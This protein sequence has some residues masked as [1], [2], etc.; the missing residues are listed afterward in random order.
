MSMNKRIFIT[1]VLMA[2][3]FIAGKLVSSRDS[4][5]ASKE[6][7]LVI[8]NATRTAG[9]SA[10]KAAPTSM[11][12]GETAN[13]RADDPNRRASENPAGSVSPP[14]S[15]ASSQSTAYLSPEAAREVL[16]RVSRR[17][18]YQWIAED[19]AKLDRFKETDAQFGSRRKMS[20][21]D[22][23]RL[24]DLATVKG[25]VH[26][27]FESAKSS[28]LRIEFKNKKVQLAV[29]YRRF[30]AKSADDLSTSRS[31]WDI[32][33]GRGVGLSGD[34]SGYFV[35]VNNQIQEPGWVEYSNFAF[36]VAFDWSGR[37]EMTVDVFGLSE[38]LKWAPVGS[39]VLKRD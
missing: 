26:F 27:K 19:D 3:A 16:A 9:H 1:A 17:D 21:G 24:L 7:T 25:A 37:S 29:R 39:A 33:N 4:V 30:D 8:E 20:E 32:S 23:K 31:S 36:P 18:L 6:S 10:D 38:D 14:F 22:W 28:E 5:T 13:V 2:F 35:V 12:G 34:G 11:S 15:G